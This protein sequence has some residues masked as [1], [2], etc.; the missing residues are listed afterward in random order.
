ML[1]DT[2]RVHRHPA[3]MPLPSALGTFSLLRSVLVLALCGLSACGN[4]DNNDE[5]AAETAIL[6][7]E[8]AARDPRRIIEVSLIQHADGSH[9]D[10]LR[11]PSGYFRKSN[12]AAMKDIADD[13]IETS[14][15]YLVSVL[16]DGELKLRSEVIGETVTAI[17]PLALLGVPDDY[18][19]RVFYP[20]G[21][22]GMN[23]PAPVT[24][25]VVGGAEQMVVP[26]YDEGREYYLAR[27]A[28]YGFVMIQCDG[29]L[30]RDG[31]HQIDKGA[32]SIKYLRSANF[33]VQV[34]IHHALLPRWRKLIV[35]AETLI[36]G[37]E[38]ASR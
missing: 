3:G 16:H 25:V 35:Q 2:R 12:I 7:R 14:A 13:Q 1:L 20:F 33:A 30:Q 17:V 28:Q 32:C 24:G 10:D 22:A 38:I 26:P 4:V 19:S 8:F 11:V 29:A 15:V 9:V 18:E 21:M 36:D 34:R 37:W 23:D 31:S 6:Q 5:I 27:D